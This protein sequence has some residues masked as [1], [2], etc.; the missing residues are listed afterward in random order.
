MSDRSEKDD[1]QEFFSGLIEPVVIPLL[2][3]MVQPF[4]SGSD[5]DFLLEINGKAIWEWRN[6]EGSLKLFAVFQENLRK[7]G[8]ELEECAF[9]RVA[10]LLNTKIRQFQ[11][12]VRAEKN[13]KRRARKKAETWIKMWLYPQEISKT[14]HDIVAEMN[15]LRRTNGHLQPPF[16]SKLNCFN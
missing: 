9:H 11:K 13:G 3:N 12:Q 15:E 7:I 5:R 4:V 10:N 8:Y 14:P 6:V 1:D 2:V 16:R